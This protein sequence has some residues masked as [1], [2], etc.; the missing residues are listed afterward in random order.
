MDQDAQIDEHAVDL[1]VDVRVVDHLAGVDVSVVGLT[2][3]L[4]VVDL[5]PRVPPLQFTD[6]RFRPSDRQ[7]VVPL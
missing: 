5:D 6:G 7:D 3:G 1:T 4:H 2:I